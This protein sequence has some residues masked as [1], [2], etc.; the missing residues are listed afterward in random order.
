MSRRL[1]T[2]ES[3]E[4]VSKGAITVTT[5]RRGLEERKDRDHRETNLQG[6]EFDRSTQR[7]SGEPS[8]HQVRPDVQ[9][10]MFRLL[11]PS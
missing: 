10:S 6:L 8:L 9:M 11:F 2:K 3:E 1:A 7:R 5:N 4:A